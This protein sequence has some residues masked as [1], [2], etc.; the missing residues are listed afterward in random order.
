LHKPNSAKGKTASDYQACSAVRHALYMPAMVALKYNPLMKVF[1]ERLK[2]DGLAPKA[3]IAACMHKLL[4]Q[5]YGVLKSRNA[6]DAQF[7]GNRL[8]FQDGI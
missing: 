5:I 7:L 1:A 3:V 6:F 2:G 8:D 4:R